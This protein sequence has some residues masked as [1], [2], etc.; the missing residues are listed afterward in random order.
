MEELL[1]YIRTVSRKRPRTI[2]CKSPLG[3]PNT[4]LIA[5]NQSNYV[6]TIVSKDIRDWKAC[7]DNFFNGL[8][9]DLSRFVSAQQIASSVPQ[10]FFQNVLARAGIKSA[11]T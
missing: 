1:L 4:Y 11:Q 8:R 2:H 6:S 10:A 5:P 9:S 7:L 3:N